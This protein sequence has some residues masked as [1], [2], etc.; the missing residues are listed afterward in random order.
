MRNVLGMAICPKPRLSS[1]I[2]T[3]WKIAREIRE[4]PGERQ[5]QHQIVVGIL[6]GNHES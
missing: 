2:R 6:Y 5:L 1:C 3:W 4:R